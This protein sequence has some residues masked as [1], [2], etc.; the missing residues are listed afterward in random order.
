[1]KTTFIY[2]L[3]DPETGEI[4]YVGK[5]NTPSIRAKQHLR[6]ENTRKCA[7]V[8]SLV[9]RGLTPKL[10]VLDEVPETEWQFWEQYWIQ[11]VSGWGFRLTNGDS[12]GLGSHR[13]SLALREKIANS[14][15]GKPQ[16]WNRIAISAYTKAGE[17]VATYQS[18]AEAAKTLGGNHGNITRAAKSLTTAYGFQWRYEQVK[19]IPKYVPNV[20]IPTEE[21][22]I[23]IADRTRGRSVSAE[24]RAKQRK[25]R[26]GVSPANKGIP[27]GP[28]L[29]KRLS[30]AC[31]TKVKVAGTPMCGGD[32][33]VFDSI[34]AAHIATGAQRMAISKC[35][36]G[37]Q[38]FAA[39]F[40]WSLV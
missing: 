39:G 22:R 2:T 7:W 32:L 3:S 12:G 36:S 28:A 5:S 14:L 37:K 18:I 31:P 19:S 33:L 26:L 15:R 30:V 35:I 6:D 40:T 24:T 13:F 20:H 38:A 25:A 1:M 4:R 29:R 8:K 27:P 23:A 10:E 9:K 21:E 16:P 34:K 17:Y 11:V